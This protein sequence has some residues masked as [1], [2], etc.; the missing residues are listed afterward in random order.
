[1]IKDVKLNNTKNLNVKKE[2]KLINSIKSED[3]IEDEKID[4]DNEE[5]NLTSSP[6]GPIGIS[7]I[8]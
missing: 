7:I 4:L 2:E 6:I 1:M 3:F 8:D 5:S